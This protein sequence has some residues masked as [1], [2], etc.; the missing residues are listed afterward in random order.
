MLWSVLEMEGG[1]LFGTDRILSW[2][3]RNKSKCHIQS[4]IGKDKDPNRSEIEQ[5]FN[6]KKMCRICHWFCVQR[7]GT[8]NEETLEV[9][10]Q[11]LKVFCPKI[12]LWPLKPFIGWI[13]CSK[14]G[15][16][17]IK[18]TRNYLWSHRIP[19]HEHCLKYIPLM[20]LRF[21]LSQQ[22]HQ[23]I[24]LRLTIP[25]HGCLYIFFSS[26]MLWKNCHYKI[27]GFSV[28]NGIGLPTSL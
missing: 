21:L 13:W 5:N 1:V 16:Y 18:C 25:T 6:L 23:R 27:T 28:S 17:S 19:N 14:D 15:T 12:S 11:R 10:L 24:S 22:L 2:V 8:L 20:F 7:L 3:G 9:P 4:N 26:W